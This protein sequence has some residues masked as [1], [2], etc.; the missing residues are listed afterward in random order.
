MN[1]T[2]SAADAADTFPKLLLE[3][4]RARGSATCMREKALGIWQAYSWSQVAAEV[5]ALACGLAALGFRRGD[6]LA[7][8]GDNRPHLYWAIS[9][10]QALGG[11]PVP[12]YQDSVAEEMAY[13]LDDADIGFAVVEDQEQVDKLLEIRQRA[14]K[15]AKIVYADARGMRHYEQ[16]FLHRYA[17]V[18]L[19]GRDFDAAHPNFFAEQVALGRSD[20][21]AIM[22]YTSGTTGKPKGVCHTHRALIGAARGGCQFDKLGPGDEV[23]SYLPMAWV[24]DNLFSYAQALAG[25]FTINCPES[26]DTVMLDM[27][28]IGPTYFFSPPRVFENLLT[29]VM[30]RMEDASLVKQKL[31]HY[32]LGVARRYGADILD[33]KPGVSLAARALYAL[34]DA[35]VYGPLRNVLGMSRVRI[36]YTAG[37]AIGPDLFRFYR[38]IGLNLKQLYGSTETCAYVCLQ[39]DGQIKLDTVGLPAPG[40]EVR[41]AD[42]GEVL[43]KSAAMLKEYYRRPDD[44]AEVFNA[45]GYFRTG[46]AGFFDTDGHLK[47]IDRAKDVGKLT[48]GAVFAPNYI[49]NKLKFFAYIK[50]AVA[51]GSGRDKVCALINIDLAAVGNWAERHNLAY[52]G[53]TDLAG[54]AQ[55]YQLVQDCVEKVNAE[56]AADPMLASSQ[57]W[58][59]LVLHKELDPDDDE[60]TRTRKVRRGFVEQKYA[61]LIQALYDGKAVQFVQTAVKFEDGRS[62]VIEADVQIRDAKVYPAVEQRKSA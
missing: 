11:V 42:D 2:R 18:Q 62:G 6:H 53:Y 12:L 10:A 51:I 55:V 1:E 48:D 34:G 20:D 57:V 46:D 8:I 28:E 15:L 23:L 7:I 40:A 60:L 9:A 32:F 49:E 50:E 61:V 30:I 22:L 14:P 39:P 33:G 24:G 3:H 16:A 52:S 26:G 44:T 19:A 17:E 56:L 5:R 25:G 43:V 45:Q 37:A 4:A 27:R 13:I 31:F 58:R 36:A 29:Q 35:L 47:I 21:V 59:F 54:K 38:S 41:I